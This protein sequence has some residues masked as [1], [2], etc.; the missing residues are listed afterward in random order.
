MLKVTRGSSD[1]R[2]KGRDEFLL[3]QRILLKSSAFTQYRFLH[4][5]VCLAGFASFATSPNPRGGGRI[6]TVHA[7][8]KYSHSMHPKR[9]RTGLV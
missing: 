2:G 1:E 3:F 8:R 9:R 6:E 4:A 7:N 5:E